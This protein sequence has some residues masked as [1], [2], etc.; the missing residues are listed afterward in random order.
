M[1]A[2]T[3]P[4][5]LAALVVLARAA[6]PDWQVTDGPPLQDEADLCAIGYDPDQGAVTVQQTPASYSA[7]TQAESYDVNCTLQS[8]TGDPDVSGA[9]ARAYVGLDA[10]AAALTADVS[11]SGAVSQALLAGS[12]LDQ[13]VT[14]NGAVATLRFTIH[15]EAWR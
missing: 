12:S 2:S 11:L 15:I 5:A 8:W 6:L 3:V 9:R 14:T 4:A 10:V 13:D 7:T 1:A